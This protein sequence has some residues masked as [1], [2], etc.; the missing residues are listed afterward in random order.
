RCCQQHDTCYDNLE[1]YRCNAKKEHYSYSWHQ[2]RPFCKNDSWCNQHSC[3]CDCTLA[4][5]LKRN[6]R[7]Y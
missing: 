1:S 3:E 2:G 5:C 4:L 7:N 6:I